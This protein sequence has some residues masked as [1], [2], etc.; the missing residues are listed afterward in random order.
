MAH[1]GRKKRP[2]KWLKISFG[3]RFMAMLVHKAWLCWCTK[4]GHIGAHNSQVG[5][6]NMAALVHI[7]WPCW[8][9][10]LSQFST[11][12]MATLVHIPSIGLS[13]KGNPICP[14]MS[15]HITDCFMWKNHMT[16][17]F[18]K[19]MA[20][21]CFLEI[22]HLAQPT[23]DTSVQFTNLTFIVRFWALW[24]SSHYLVHIFFLFMFDITSVV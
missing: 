13:C 22:R 17:R 11:Q 15:H 5:A 3:S 2:K 16:M 8:C 12:N 7:T 18:P 4:F 23:C 24:L 9:T 19:I 10:K 14:H 21:L 6:Q 20:F 1:C